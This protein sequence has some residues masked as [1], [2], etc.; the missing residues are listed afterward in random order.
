MRVQVVRVH[1]FKK[2]M[3]VNNTIYLSFEQRRAEHHP[4]YQGEREREGGAVRERESKR[5]R[6]KERD[7]PTYLPKSSS[8]YPVH[9]IKVGLLSLSFP[10]QHRRPTFFPGPSNVQRPDTTDLRCST[11]FDLS[12]PLPALLSLACLPACLS[13]LHHTIL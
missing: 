6:V 11:Y 4:T 8:V 9:I 1:T 10:I 2:W 7:L 3:C 13:R 12:Y 5:E